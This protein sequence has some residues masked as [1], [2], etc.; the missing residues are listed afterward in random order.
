[1]VRCHIHVKGHVQRVGFRKFTK[2]IARKYN[3]VGF[4][5]NVKDGTVEADIQGKQEHVDMLVQALRVGNS[6]S[7]VQA[8]SVKKMKSLK[9]Y[10][11]FRIRITVKTSR[12]Y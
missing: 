7:E 6:A 5:R 2:K 1:M 10:T 11:T 8:V 3:I 4:V 12:E 9:K